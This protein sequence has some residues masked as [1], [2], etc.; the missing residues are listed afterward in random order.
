MSPFTS[1]SRIS[2]WQRGLLVLLLLWVGA[3]NAHL[4]PREVVF[5]DTGVADW[6]VLR[7]GVKPGV[8]VALIGGNADGLAQM[9]AW[10]SGGKSGYD[11]VHVLSHG[12]EGQVQLGTLT[13]D[14]ATVGTRVA[15]LAALGLALTSEGDLLLYGSGGGAYPD[16]GRPRRPR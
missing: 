11:A 16:G 2:A 7:D 12:A 4:A 15:D 13:L 1:L 14:T 8:E 9:A 6:Q 10:M 3:L 5:I